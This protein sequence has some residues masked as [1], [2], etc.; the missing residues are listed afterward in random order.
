MDRSIQDQAPCTPRGAPVATVTICSGS[1]SGQSI[2]LRRAVSLF[3]TKRGSKFVLRDPAVNRRHCVIVN[4]G[5]RLFLRDLDTHGK[6]LRN[7]LKVEQEVLEDADHIT[8]GPWDF[9]I[10]LKDPQIQGGRDSS[11]IVDLE[12]DPTV[13]AIEDTQTC[14]IGK[15]PREVTILGRSPGADFSINDR[16]VSRVHTIIFS[17]LGRPAIFDLASENG[18]WVNDERVVFTMLNNGDE[19]RLGSRTLK[20]RSSTQSVVKGSG[21]NGSAVLTPNPFPNPE[22]TLSDLIDISPESKPS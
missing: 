22:G 12:P 14:H 17:Y 5:Y 11:V 19:I 2:K 1:G 6:T 10:D 13:L 16:E 20:F 8:I 18:T 3:G 7:S 21:D 9:R 15:L 4:T